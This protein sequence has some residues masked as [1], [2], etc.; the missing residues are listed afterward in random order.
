MPESLNQQRIAD[1]YTSL[2]HVLCSDVTSFP[3][4]EVY[5]GAGNTTGLSLSATQDR[6]V[7]N[8]YIYPEGYDDNP[9][10]WL[11]AFFPVGVIMLTTTNNNPSQCTLFLNFVFNSFI[12]LFIE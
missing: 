4:N 6:V 3:L 2:F 1:Y 7:I 8:N 10:E 5:D 9:T 11:D 12:L